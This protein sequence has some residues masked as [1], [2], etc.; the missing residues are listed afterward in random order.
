MLVNNESKPSATH[1]LPHTMM[2]LAGTFCSTL[3]GGGGGL[4]FYTNNW[5]A[6]SSPVCNNFLNTVV[7]DCSFI[8][9][10]STF[11]PTCQWADQFYDQNIGEYEF[12]KSNGTLLCVQWYKYYDSP[13]ILFRN[14]KPLQT[15]WHANISYRQ[16]TRV[17]VQPREGQIRV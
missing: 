1:P 11:S 14:L 12:M 3:S 5:F 10:R 9:I 2:L 15:C 7:P 4:E 6:R 16:T 17:W 8:H 13:R